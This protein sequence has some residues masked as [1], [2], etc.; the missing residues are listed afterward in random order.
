MLP[1]H[2]PVLPYLPFPSVG[3][4]LCGSPLTAFPLSAVS[5]R[6]CAQAEDP[7][8][9]GGVLLQ[10]PAVLSPHFVPLPDQ[11]LRLP[12]RCLFELHFLPGAE[13]R[14]QRKE[15]EPQ[16]KH[17]NEVAKTLMTMRYIKGMECKKIAKA[18]YY[19]ETHV[20]HVMQQSERI[21]TAKQDNSKRQ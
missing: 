8:L 4:W 11:F 18:M 21:I 9:A 7:D 1:A 12:H 16:L 3:T 14:E 19:S 15:L 13:L 6:P 10:H 17:L 5:R 20:F 2:F